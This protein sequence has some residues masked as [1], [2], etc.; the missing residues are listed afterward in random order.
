MTDKPDKIIPAGF[1]QIEPADPALSADFAPQ[2]QAQVSNRW[3]PPL[4]TGLMIIAAIVF[5]W[6]PDAVEKPTI[7]ATTTSNGEVSTTSTAGAGEPERSPWAEAQAAKI[8]KEAQDVL[9]QLLDLQFELEEQG[10]PDWA[11]DA[12]NAALET[13][14]LA[15]ESYRAKDFAVARDHYSDAVTAMSSVRDSADQIFADAISQGQVALNELNA[16]GA[17]EAFAL[18]LRINPIDNDAIAGSAR[19]NNIE[20]VLAL[21]QQ[22]DILYQ[23]GDLLEAKEHLLVVR[24]LDPEYTGA[25]ATLATIEDELIS[26]RFNTAMSAGYEA[27]NAGNFDRAEKQFRVAAGLRPQA[28]EVQTAL[29]EAQDSRALRA[30]ESARAT[31][32]KAESEEQWQKALDTYEGLLRQDN[33]LVFARVGQIKAGARATLDRDLGAAIE[34][35][36]RLADSRAYEAARILFRDASTIGDKGPILQQQ[37]AA[38]AG[39]LEDAIKPQR[40]ELRSDK[41]TAVTLRKVA[42]LGTFESHSLTLKPG[43]YVAVGSRPGY[44]DV[45]RE[46]TVRAGNNLEPIIVQCTE[47]I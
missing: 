29:R 2:E 41:Q 26:R 5:F 16:Q 38:L 44:R 34:S 19:A 31:A 7:D 46:F 10:A 27:L 12:Y 37:I 4:L 24:R 42:V 22:A 28:G 13:A 20:Q 21:V 43:T 45:R 36:E 14:A 23:R 33:S 30:I 25:T 6:L 39:I 35:P 18:A 8:R 32:E 3:I 11:T 47:S 1:E 15:D 17:R 40:I 9:G